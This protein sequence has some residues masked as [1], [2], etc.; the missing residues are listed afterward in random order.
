[1]LLT[2]EAGSQFVRT[3][4][5]SKKKKALSLKLP[6]MEMDPD[7]CPAMVDG[8]RKDPTRH[9]PRAKMRRHMITFHK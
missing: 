8:L 3:T 6:V 4:E 9:L 5:I 7:Y 2:S 1:M